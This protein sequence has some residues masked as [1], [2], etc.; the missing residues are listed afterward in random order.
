MTEMY[1]RRRVG[2][3]LMIVWI[4]ATLNFLAPRLTGKDPI[5]QQ[6]LRQTAQGGSVEAGSA[7]ISRVYRQKFG[8]VQHIWVQ[9][10]NY[11]VSVGP[12]DFGYSITNYPETVDD[13]LLTALPWTIGLLLTATLLAFAIGS[14]L[15]AIGGWPR[16]HAAVHWLMPPLLTFSAV[17]YYLLA[18]VLL[19][20]FAFQLRLVPI[21]GGYS[22]GTIPG[23]NPQ[24]VLD[25]LGHSLLPA[26]SI[27]LAGIRSLA[28]GMRAMMVGVQ[29]E[30]FMLMAEA[31]GLK[32]ST[33]FLRYAVR[34]ALLPQVTSQVWLSAR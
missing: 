10:G 22:A 7:D 28:V 31:K 15:G 5:D 17:P 23:L 26:L 21:F 4:A 1:V 3:F 30:D 12:R 27:V 8:L 24:F 25:V 29:C 9:Y 32:G 2:L 14:I 16:A 6:L 34:N 20:I 18:L 19:E 33:I 11:L 13:I